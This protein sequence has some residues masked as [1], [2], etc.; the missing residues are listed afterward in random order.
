[1]KKLKKLHTKLSFA[2]VAIMT[3]APAFA[4]VNIGGICD[5][6]KQLSSVFKVLR[7]LAFVGA[8]F[9]IATWAWGY[10][11]DP[12]DGKDLLNDVKKKGVGMLVGFILLFGIGLLLSFIMSTAGGEAMGCKDVIINWGK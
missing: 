9:M 11:S 5:L 2:I 12:K 3:S 8:A 1:M 7:T 4:D 10:I 6:I